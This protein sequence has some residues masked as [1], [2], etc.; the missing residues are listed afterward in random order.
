[1]FIRASRLSSRSV[2]L[3]RAYS[4]AAQQHALLKPASEVVQGDAAELD[5]I[6]VLVLNR[7]DARNALSRQM[8]DE[9]RDYISRLSTGNARVA[10]LHSLGP[11]FCAG[12]DL[13]ER[14]GMSQP[15]VAQFLDDLNAMV[16]ELEALPIPTIAAVP[17]P[18]LGGGTE[19]ALGCDLR[20]GQKETSFAL[21]ETKLGIIP[22]AG[23]TQRMTH[24]LGKS[25]AMELIF[26]GRR[27]GAEEA[28]RLGLIDVL[29]KDGQT[30]LDAAI[31]LSKLML[32]SAP[33]SLRAAKQ[34]IKSAPGTPIEQG[35]KNER[36]AY[37]PLL[38]S[39]DR[40]EGLRAFAEKR[41]PVFQGK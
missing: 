16:C 9:L 41:K 25:K 18:A 30:A 28:A 14:K 40:L 6:Q 17:G 19:L 10:I 1:M 4:A 36:A 24:L 5:G 11:V 27:V 39:E 23:G 13:R 37:K 21:P 20:T 3:V 15:E 12:A 38:V 33:L 8:V 31:D 26:T 22:G 7:P 35:L 2:P 34:A 32:T 29:A